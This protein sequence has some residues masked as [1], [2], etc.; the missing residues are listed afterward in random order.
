MLCAG[1]RQE[2][3]GAPLTVDLPG[4][5]LD[6]VFPSGVPDGA[7][8]PFSARELDLAD[9]PALAG[10]SDSSSAT[11]NDTGGQEAAL[12]SAAPSTHPRSAAVVGVLLIV[13]NL[14]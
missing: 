6:G 2:Q 7:L 11:M 4:S 10:T 13:F 5:G 8:A 14:V 1:G 3:D 9:V 12:T